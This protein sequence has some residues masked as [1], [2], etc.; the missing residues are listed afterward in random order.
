MHH[1][2]QLVW[3]RIT[4]AGPQNNQIS[5]NFTYFK[6]EPVATLSNLYGHFDERKKLEENKKYIL[7]G[8]APLVTYPP[9]ANSTTNL[10]SPYSKRP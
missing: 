2:I 8:V 4:C 6:S 9:P 1:E 3:Y 7:D 5:N 10:P